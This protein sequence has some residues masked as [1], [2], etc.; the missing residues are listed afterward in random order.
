MD[1]KMMIPGAWEPR[2]RSEA[3]VAETSPGPHYGPF[4]PVPT[5]P[6]DARGNGLGGDTQHRE[7]ATWLKL[8]IFAAVLLAAMWLAM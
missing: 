6:T 2:H 5:G 8:S 4:T 1:R 7:L 3:A